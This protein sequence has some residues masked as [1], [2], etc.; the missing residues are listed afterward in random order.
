MTP[1][2]FPE[3]KRRKSIPLIRNPANSCWGY[4]S[5]R[6]QD[7]GAGRGLWSLDR[8]GI[9]LFGGSQYAPSLWVTMT[10]EKQRNERRQ[11]KSFRAFPS[12]DN[13][14]GEQIKDKTFV[15][16]AAIAE[17]RFLPRQQSWLKRRRT[18][19]PDRFSGRFKRGFL[20]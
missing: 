8:A 18:C 16:A 19:D 12:Q 2:D 13:R 5:L 4:R 9:C 11:R 14:E 15:T 10:E 20:Q 6:G 3:W 1:S 17:W 7:P